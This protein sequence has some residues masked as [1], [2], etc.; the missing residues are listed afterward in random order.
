MGLPTLPPNPY[1]ISVGGPC[2]RRDLSSSFFM[3]CVAIGMWNLLL[4]AS[5]FSSL[6]EMLMSP[7]LLRSLIPMTP[8]RSTKPPKPPDPPIRRI[9]RFRPEVNYYFQ[10]VLVFCWSFLDVMTNGWWGLC[11][12]TRFLAIYYCGVVPSLSSLFI[13]KNPL[14]WFVFLPNSA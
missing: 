6:F 1:F 10:S 5:S 11:V 7:A 9:R 4:S 13:V 14:C 8:T 12:S 3:V 2:H